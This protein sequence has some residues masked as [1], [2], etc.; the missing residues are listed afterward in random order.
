MHLQENRQFSQDY[1]DPE[2]RSIANQLTIHFREG[3][4]LGPVT[5]EFPIGHKRRRTE[6][7]PLLEEKFLANAAQ[8]PKKEELCA[9]FRSQGDFDQKPISSLF[10][11]SN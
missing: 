5:L 2:K 11:Y 4:S 3:S 10:C 1:L 9:L 6:A 8:F 7:I